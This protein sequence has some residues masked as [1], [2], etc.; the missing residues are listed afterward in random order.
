MPGDSANLSAPGPLCF[1][2]IDGDHLP[3][4]IENDFYLVWRALTPGGAVAFHDYRSI[5]P[6][7]TAKI[8]ELML[9][10]RAEITD[11]EFDAFKHILYAVKHR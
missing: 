4:Y 10:H 5:G 9:R 8:D 3:R 7:I 2:F 1:G 6:A 11:I